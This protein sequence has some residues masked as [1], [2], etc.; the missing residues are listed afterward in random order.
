M[1]GERVQTLI[2]G[3][4]EA[5]LITDEL[6]RAGDRVYLSVGCHTRLP[7]RYRGRD[8]IWWLREM[9]IDQTPVEQRGPSRLLPVISGARARRPHRRA[10]PLGAKPSWASGTNQC[11]L[12]RT[13]PK[14]FTKC[15]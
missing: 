3:G 5:G 1:P 4:G 8:L 13:P 15:E 10:R 11:R 9:G 14:K 2:V 12:G 7:R 6:L